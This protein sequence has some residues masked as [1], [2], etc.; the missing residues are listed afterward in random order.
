MSKKATYLFNRVNVKKVGM[1]AFD[2]GAKRVSV[3]L[4]EQDGR[5]VVELKKKRVRV[6]L[7]IAEN[8]NGILKL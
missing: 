4:Q 5:Y 2:G 7:R 6:I 3:L 8:L 1:F